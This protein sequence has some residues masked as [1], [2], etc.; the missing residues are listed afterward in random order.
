MSSITCPKCGK[1][2]KSWSNFKDLKMREGIGLALCGSFINDLDHFMCGES[3][4]QNQKPDYRTTELYYCEKCK[5][6]FL[7]CPGCKSYIHLDCMPKETRTLL[8]CNGCNKKV[9]YAEEDY[10]MGGG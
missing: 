1:T 10:T 3:R 5:K 4:S 6:Y 7:K 2:A 8:T 9:L